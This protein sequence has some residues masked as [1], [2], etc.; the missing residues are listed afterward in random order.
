MAK[1][2]RN[3]DPRVLA[4]RRSRLSIYDAIPT[5]HSELWFPLDELERV[6]CT[7]LRGMPLTGLPLRTRSKVVKEAV[8]RALG[9]PVPRTFRRTQPRFPGQRFDVYVQKSDNLQIWNEEVELSRRY[10]I[11]RVNEDDEISDLKVVTGSQL[12]KLDHTGTLTQK[13]QARLMP[14]KVEAE[15][16]AR[17]TDLISPVVA[18]HVDL[19]SRQPTDFPR[20]HELL[21]IETLFNRMRT[22]LGKCFSDPGRSQERNRGAML[23]RLVCEQLGYTSYRDDGRFPDIGHQLLEIKLQ[24]SPTIDLGLVDPHSEDILDMPTPNAMGIRHCDVRYAVFVAKTDGE[25]VTLERLY[26]TTGK[27]FFVRFAQFQGN[28][29]NK[30]IQIPLPASLF[31]GRPASGT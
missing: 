18:A 21:P 17:D 14:T 8:C 11:V 27:M 4:I 10:V 20:A 24:T 31:E 28:V 13:Y 5:S 30:K 9:Y 2:T 23:H 6:L 3:A 7:A 19:S 22:L 26:V 29:V 15:L 25:M 1:P 16:V 12:A